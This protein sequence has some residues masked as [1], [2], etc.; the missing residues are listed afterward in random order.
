MSTVSVVKRN[1][2]SS[3]LEPRHGLML[4]GI[5][6]LIWST[7]GLIVRLLGTLDPW[8][9][10]FWRSFFAALFV[11]GYVVWRDRGKTLETFRSVGWAGLI[12]AGAFTIASVGFV[13]ALSLTSVANTLV[14]FS[15]SP[16]IAGLLALVLLG[17]KVH[18]AGWATML[19]AC[20]GVVIMVSASA[21]SGSLAG[22]AI[23]FCVATAI[24][25][26]NVTIRKNRHIRMTPATC[27]GALLAALIA[28]P[29]AAP[30]T[31][32][33][34]QFALLAVFGTLQFGLGMVLFTRGAP[35]APAAQVALILL[36]EPIL[37]PVWVWLALGEFPGTAAL[38]GGGLVLLALAVNT[39]L[40][41]R[42]MRK[43][44][45]LV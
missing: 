7:G 32:S 30:L 23:A 29:L 45:P 3:M 15:T 11:F 35:L 40:D 27:L 33:N 25:V 22:D 31:V 4:V 39:T 13:V 34:D 16:L 9:I 20:I 41:L 26:G 6:A 28:L 2:T 14:L 44:M 43:T 24:A 38:I 5:A 36:L 12:V 19:V 10:V 42:R 18:P 1:P 37:G 21:S 17:E 8:T